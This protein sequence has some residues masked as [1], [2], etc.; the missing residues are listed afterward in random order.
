[1]VNI[2]GDASRAPL[3]ITIRPNSAFHPRDAICAAMVAA[4]VGAILA[5][6]FVSLGAWPIALFLFLTFC[7]LWMAV[8]AV[9]RE[10]G[11]VERISFDEWTVTI[12]RHDAKS[13]DTHLELNGPWVQV[14]EKPSLNGGCEYLALRSHGHEIV[15]GQCLSLDERAAVGRVLRTRLREI[16]H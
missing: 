3:H 15:L 14:I 7:G 12:D 1:M 10:R 13:G 2:V 9:R 4:P 6:L 16:H 5:A 11:E 8:L